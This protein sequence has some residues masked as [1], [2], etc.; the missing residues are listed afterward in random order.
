[1]FPIQ[2]RMNINYSEDDRTALTNYSNLRRHLAI[3]QNE[4]VK[5]GYW[6]IGLAAEQMQ[7]LD[8][9]L[10]KLI[11]NSGM[12]LGHHGANRKP[13]PM[14]SE[15]IKGQNWSDDVQTVL[16]YE[17]Y[18]LDP[19]TGEMDFSR[20]GGLKILQQ[21]FSNR[22]RSTGRFFQASI[23]YGTRQFGCRAM[24]GLQTNS[25]GSTN[26][27]WFM[28]MMGFPDRLEITP[29][30]LRKAADGELDLFRKIDDYVAQ[31]SPEDV[32]S[33]AILEHDHDFLMDDR[34]A[35]EHL[36]KFYA[37]LVHWAANHS[38]LRVINYEDL[39]HL[40][41]DDRTKVIARNDLLKAGWQVIHSETAL[42]AY[43]DLDG[44]YLS[45]AE[46]FEGFLQASLE[47]CEE[48][49]VMENFSVGELLGPIDYFTS[50]L[51]SQGSK[52]ELPVVA[53]SDVIQAACRLSKERLDFVP[54]QVTVGNWVLNPAEFLV[55]M[56]ETF[57]KLDQ[58]ANFIKIPMRAMDVLP[59]GVREFSKADALTKLQFWTFK[60]ERWSKP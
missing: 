51:P 38:S 7:R 28:G 34:A 36:W 33:I 6:F 50:G 26:A 9:E 41:A 60:P 35:R 48:K 40:I 14:L 8:P 17:S 31:T 44:D 23:L 39:F 55:V 16:D 30:I 56:A 24:M 45:L 13:T 58:D 29:D 49:E 20:V 25:G 46:V 15:R 37:Q 53:G 18:H 5:T 4:G 3:F 32:Q 11:S 47:F 59:T 57:L 19:E 43:I 10:L 1:M 21:L 27:G 2:F 42:P 22:I 12:A 54:T 52:N